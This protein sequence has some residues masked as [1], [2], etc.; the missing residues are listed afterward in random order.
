MF[1]LASCIEL[2]S[3]AHSIFDMCEM[4]IDILTRSS[5][6]KNMLMTIAMPTAAYRQPVKYTT[7]GVLELQLLIPNSG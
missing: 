5:E 4:K 3:I 6:A 2:S 7:A 1:D